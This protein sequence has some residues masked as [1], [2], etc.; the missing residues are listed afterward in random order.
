MFFVQKKRLIF[1]RKCW[2][3]LKSS[4]RK[5]H[6]EMRKTYEPYQKDQITPEAAILWG[7]IPLEAEKCILKNAF[8]AK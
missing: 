2:S 5:V 4:R 3:S 7:A 6:A 8:C 1:Q